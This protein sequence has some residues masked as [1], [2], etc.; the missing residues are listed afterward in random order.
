[1]PSLNSHKHHKLWQI[2]I[3]I[4][5]DHACRHNSYHFLIIVLFGRFS[6]VFGGYGFGH[7]GVSVIGV[8]L[9]VIV[10]LVLTGR[11]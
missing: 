2:L 4:G 6:G 1:M 11:L 5:S 7:R 9:I 3:E 10:V 8:I